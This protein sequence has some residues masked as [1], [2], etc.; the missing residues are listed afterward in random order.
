[1]RAEFLSFPNFEMKARAY[2]PRRTIGDR[3]CEAVLMLAE[4][5][6]RLLSHEETPWASITFS[7]SRHEMML[8]FEGPDAVAAG[9]RLI[10]A[11]PDHEFTIPGHLMA[12]A[13]VSAVEHN[14]LPGPRMVVTVTL[15]LLEE[16]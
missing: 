7:G 9:E 2:H 10:A 6:A 14:L 16:A 12:D 15:L 3:V 8:D 11:L 5:Q 13:T 1:M 4:A